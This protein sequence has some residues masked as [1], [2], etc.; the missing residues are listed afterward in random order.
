IGVLLKL[1]KMKLQEPLYA[2]RKLKLP[3]AEVNAGKA[4]KAAGRKAKASV[5]RV[6]K[7]D[8]LD[9]IARQCNTNVN[10]LRR[11]NKIRRADL[12]YVDQKLR[13]PPS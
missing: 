8:T 6:K 5:Y 4:E 1:N 10:E 13:L 9:K 7:G 11:L 3:H 2:G 12:L